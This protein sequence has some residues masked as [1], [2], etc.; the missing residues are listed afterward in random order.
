MSGG[1]EGE[2]ARLE[3]YTQFTVPD[4]LV[5]Q[6]P[7]EPRDSAR[8]MVVR[9]AE[10]TI[11]HH[12]VR[13]LPELLDPSYVLV[14]NTSKVVNCKLTGL[15]QASEGLSEREQVFYLLKQTGE[16]SWQCS[17]DGL[18]QLPAG[19][20]IVLGDAEGEGELTCRVVAVDADDLVEVAFDA[21]ADGS[22]LAAKVAALTAVPLPPYV[23]STLGEGGYQTVYAREEGSVAAPTAGLHFTEELLAR[24]EKGGVVREEVNLHVGYGTFAHVHAQDLKDHVMHSESYVVTAET[25]DRLNAHRRA[26]RKLLTVGTTS[27]RCLETV[28]SADGV[29]AP[30]SGETAIFIHP[31]YKFKAS[32]ALMTNFHM[33]GLSP[34]MLVAAHAGYEL[35]MRAYEEAIRERYRFYSFG[36]SMLIL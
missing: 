33:P 15:V 35:T 24:L 19:T 25:A 21:P 13:D 34:I 18:E 8:L 32:D 14:V 6:T 16:R 1:K 11:S 4:E 17:G 27:T 28:T 29:V 2:H 20:A 30:G 31:P 9:R 7:A 5:A 36:D 26:G 10:G 23:T 22:D 3:A 12:H